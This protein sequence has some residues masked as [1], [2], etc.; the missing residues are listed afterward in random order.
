MGN[1]SFDDFTLR[2][3]FRLETREHIEGLES[4][5][6]MGKEA[7]IFSAKVKDSDNIIVKIYRLE[8]CDFTRMYEY[9]RYD[10]RYIT[11]GKNRRKIIF[12]W[13]QREYRNLLKLRESGIRVPKPIAFVDNILLMEE[14]R[15]ESGI[16][17]KLKDSYVED[18]QAFFDKLLYY[19]RRMYHSAGLIHGD[20]SAFNILNSNGEPVIIDVS[21]AIP[22]NTQNADDLLKRDC[23]NVCSYFRKLGLKLDENELYVQIRTK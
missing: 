2:N 17:P 5:I 15:S 18:P 14:I 22:L 16:A 21:Q 4:S 20:L 13:C 7:N 10:P 3:L 19:M 12:S 23:K 6:S 11:L 8:T 9:I 1:I